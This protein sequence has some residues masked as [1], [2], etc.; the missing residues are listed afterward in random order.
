MVVIRLIEAA[1]ALLLLTS[2]QV[3]QAG[4]DLFALLLELRCLISFSHLRNN[5]GGVQ[6]AVVITKLFGDSA[7]AVQ[8]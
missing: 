4:L 3:E 6:G 1:P 8:R 2:L 5:C 7:R